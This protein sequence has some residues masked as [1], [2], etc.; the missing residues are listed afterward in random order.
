MHVPN[1]ILSSLCSFIAS[2]IVRYICLSERAI[3]KVVALRNDGERQ[4]LLE[5]M[6]RCAAIK[7]YALFI[8]S[9]VL[10]IL[11][12]Y[13]VS[14]FC[15]VFKNSQK[16]YLINT[17]VAFIVCNL[18]PVVTTWIPTVMRKKAIENR[19]NTLYRASQI[20]AIF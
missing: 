2:L 5:K 12:W 15:A 8:C 7:I 10:T 13:Y 20:V 3:S 11:C 14:A 19:N 17:L 1:I 4:K 9:T 6:K 18:W 16:H